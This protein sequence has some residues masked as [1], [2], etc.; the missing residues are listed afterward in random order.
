[1]HPATDGI[2][3]AACRRGLML[4]LACSAS[5]VW[6]NAELALEQGCLSCHGSPPR[7]K[8]L[9]FP[10]LAVECARYQSEPGAEARLAEKLRKPPLFGG[11]DA[12]ER[13]SQ[14]NAQ[15]LLRWIIQGA[16]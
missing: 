10:E 11:M 3:R 4:G 2:M 9:P 1:M 8:A 5:G 13:L 7:G 16:R 15:V 6:A 12:H 14:E